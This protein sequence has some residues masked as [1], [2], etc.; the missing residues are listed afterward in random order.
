MNILLNASTPVPRYLDRDALTFVNQIRSKSG[1]KELSSKGYVYEVN[2][3][4]LRPDL[5]DEGQSVPV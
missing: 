4:T 1:N 5:V 2:M 3:P